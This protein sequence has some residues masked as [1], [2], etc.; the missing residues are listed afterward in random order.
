MGGSVPNPTYQQ[1]CTGTTGHA[2]VVDLQFHPAVVSYKAL[3][4]SF[5]K[6]HDPTTLNRQGND[7]GTQYRSVIFYYGPQQR[8]QARAAIAAET[9]RRGVPVTTQL[10]DGHAHRLY[11]AEDEHQRYL[12]KGGQNASKG[13]T[14]PISCYGN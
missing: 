7:R 14:A 10:V 2:E 5:W 3:L 11:E 1:V 13:A 12:E 4:N 6:W 8:A 9:K